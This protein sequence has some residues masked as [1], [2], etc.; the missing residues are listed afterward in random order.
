[1]SL[2]L[3]TLMIMQS[4]ATACAGAIMLFAWLQSRTTAV[5]A[6]WGF[7]NLIAAAGVISLVLGLVLHMPVYSVLAAFL[8]SS[9]SSLMWKVARLIDAKPAPFIALLGPMIVVLA[10]AVPATRNAAGLL[11][12]IIGAAY[13]FAAAASLWLGRKEQ[14]L[15]RWPLMI[16]TAM[17]SSALFV[18]TYSTLQGSIGQDTVP[19]PPSLFGFIHFE[20]IIFA[21]GTSVFLLAL[22]KERSEVAGRMAGYIDPLT[23]IDNRAGF[24]GKAER[25][26][27]RCRH[28]SA[29]ATVMMFDLDRFKRINDTHGHAVG[30]AVIRAF[31]KTTAASLRPNDVFGRL[32]GEEFAVV[33]P[34]SGIEAAYIRAERIR[35]AFAASGRF[36]GGRQVDA[37]VSCGLS[38]NV[39]GGQT[40]TELLEAADWALYDAKASG[41][42]RVKR[43][44]EIRPATAQS[45]VI[46]VA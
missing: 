30:D 25:L 17:H 4:F 40:L 1:M 45:A 14:L 36:V 31:C 23:G 20:S 44:G 29:P 16:L 21:V 43:S 11:A 42:N 35:C 18:G 9:Q 6:I 3:P 24:I 8:L 32:G 22:V 19:A 5:F 28:D 13:C 7:A 2:D 27:E 41:R 37:T 38:V 12:L 33:L 15:A 26:L 46:R 10:A 39:N 34:G